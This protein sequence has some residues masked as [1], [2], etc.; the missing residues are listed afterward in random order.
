MRIRLRTFTEESYYINTLSNTKG[1]IKFYNMKAILTIPTVK[2]LRTQQI[3]D[4]LE[5][6]TD[7]FIVQERVPR[8]KAKP[9]LF[10]FYFDELLESVSNGSIEIGGIGTVPELI[11]ELRLVTMR[12]ELKKREEDHKRDVETYSQVIALHEGENNGKT[13]TTDDEL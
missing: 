10:P 13:K 5:A 4:V 1:E 11:T 3:F 2:N 8:G 7:H 9:E 6:N 12:A